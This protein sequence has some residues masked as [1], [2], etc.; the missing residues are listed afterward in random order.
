MITFWIFCLVYLFLSCLLIRSLQNGAVL[1]SD[2]NEA[3]RPCHTTHPI[4]ND[5]RL[6]PPRQPNRLNTNTKIVPSSSCVEGKSAVKPCSYRPSPSYIVSQPCASL[7]LHSCV[8][9]DLLSQS[10]VIRNNR[11]IRG[12]ACSHQT[13]EG[14]ASARSTRLARFR[15]HAHQSSASGA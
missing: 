1:F 14:W 8:P 2:I 13:Q 15:R 5:R 11:S 9:P 7:T 10:D 3:Q 6:A 4:V 12:V